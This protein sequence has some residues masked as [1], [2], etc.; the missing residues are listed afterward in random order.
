MEAP[1]TSPPPPPEA[2][3]NP[4]RATS[5]DITASERRR[6]FSLGCNIERQQTASSSTGQ[7]VTPQIQ[8]QPPGINICFYI[9][10]NPG[11]VY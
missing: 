3:D 5:L 8:L 9:L 6:Q 1:S 2:P 7:F 11:A 10:A 4:S